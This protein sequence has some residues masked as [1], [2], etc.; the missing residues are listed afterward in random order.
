M[1]CSRCFMTSEK[2][3]KHSHFG[4][5]EGDVVAA[6]QLLIVLRLLSLKTLSGLLQCYG[7]DII[8]R[9]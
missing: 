7:N 2:K 8:D 6:K 5:N 4:K 9:R 3:I 1:F